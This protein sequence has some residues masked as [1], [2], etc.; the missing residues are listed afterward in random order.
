M[1]EHYGE[2]SPLLHVVPLQLQAHQTACVRGTD[3]H[4][5]KSLEKSVTFDELQ[6][7]AKYHFCFWISMK[8]RALS[9]VH[10][11]QTYIDLH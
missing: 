8:T 7:S 3:M 1:P 9:L 4:N 10:R 6:R 2:L 11:K 5:P